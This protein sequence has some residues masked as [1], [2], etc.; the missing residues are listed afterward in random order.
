MIGNRAVLKRSFSNPM[1]LY[2]GLEFFFL[3]MLITSG[4]QLAVFEN[5]KKYKDDK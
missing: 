4:M 2:A 3:R 1:G 5:A